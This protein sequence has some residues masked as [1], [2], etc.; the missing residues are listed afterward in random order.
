MDII[1]LATIEHDHGVNTYVC[2]THTRAWHEIAKFAREFWHEIGNDPQPP[3]G[4][5]NQEI[6]DTYFA[7]KHDS[8]FYNIEEY[9]IL[10]ISDLTEAV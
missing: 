4:M 1:Y 2:A 7:A 8:E 6:V 9:P 10:G 3:A 5:T